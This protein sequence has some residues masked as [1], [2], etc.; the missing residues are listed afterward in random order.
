MDTI[1]QTHIEVV[2][3]AERLLRDEGPTVA[4]RVRPEW[5]VRG[6]EDLAPTVSVVF[7][8]GD[9]FNLAAYEAP[10]LIALGAVELV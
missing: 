2:E 6:F 7:G 10:D 1:T 5:A 4:V 8:E 3:R 9:V